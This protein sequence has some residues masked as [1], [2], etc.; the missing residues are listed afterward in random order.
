MQ[1]RLTKM[2]NGKKYRLENFAD[3]KY[4]AQKIA[5]KLK[6]TEGKYGYLIKVIKSPCPVGWNVWVYRPGVIY[7]KGYPFHRQNVP[8]YTYEY[9]RI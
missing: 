1:R 7:P 3:N 6:K 4:E 5:E 9:P 8:S 2:V